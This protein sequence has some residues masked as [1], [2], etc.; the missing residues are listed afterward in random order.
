MT[1]IICRIF[2][3]RAKEIAKKY[4]IYPSL[5]NPYDMREVEAKVVLKFDSIEG[6]PVVIISLK[7]V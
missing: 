4:G 1:E 2:G 5:E 3:D 6:H 7:E